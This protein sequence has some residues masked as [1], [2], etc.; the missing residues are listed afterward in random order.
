[1]KLD[2]IDI[3]ILA[4]LQ[5]EGRITNKALAERV[6]LTPRPC[7]TR[8]HRLMEGGFILKTRAVLN[9]AK[10][11]NP[12]V[13]YA[14]ITLS[15]QDNAGSR[16]FESHVKRIPEVTDCFEVSGAVDFVARFVCPSLDAYYRITEDLLEN[17][18]IG[19]RRIDS[20]IVLR[21]VVSNRGFPP[22]VLEAALP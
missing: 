18:A 16:R 14:H 11:G 1:M 8:L 10:F 9:P 3:R 6:G 13:V 12:V 21:T 19:V 20:T 17:D 5:E 2:P 7:L 15:R 4:I 22:S